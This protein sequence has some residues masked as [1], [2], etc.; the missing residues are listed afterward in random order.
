[1]ATT[2]YLVRHAAHDRVHDT[3][4]GRMPG[5][6]LGERGR[7]QAIRIAERLAGEA[8]ATVVSSPLERALQ[9]A[10]PIAR[11]LATPLLVLDTL[12]EIDFGAWTGR[13]F[14]SLA[15]DNVWR[16]WNSERST[17]APPG[18]ESFAAA[19]TRCV[20]AV[21][22]LVEAYPDTGI[23]AVTHCDVIRAALCAFLNCRSLDDYD[24]LEISPGSITRL[25]FWT[26]G[27]K[28]LGVNEAL[29]A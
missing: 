3:L 16:A 8:V 14:Q 27:W 23:V 2:L 12:N 22:D 21:R 26:G 6:T 29:A 28:V 15:N 25:V 19:Q 10:E 17:V 7:V 20:T 13:S 18:G 4:C 5:V 1:V 11:K 9:T 24:L